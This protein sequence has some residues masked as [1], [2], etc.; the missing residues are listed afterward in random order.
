M[1]KNLNENIV[2]LKISNGHQ[3]WICKKL[4]NGYKYFGIYSKPVKG[5]K[6]D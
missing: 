6:N 1:N 5:G 3:I 4:I 2:E